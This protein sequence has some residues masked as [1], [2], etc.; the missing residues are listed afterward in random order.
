MKGLEK[1]Y[2]TMIFSKTLTETLPLKNLKNF[3]TIPSNMV[4]QGKHF[5]NCGVL[6]TIRKVI[7]CRL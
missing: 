4:C 7:K 3:K 2:P 5:S 6:Y 1:R